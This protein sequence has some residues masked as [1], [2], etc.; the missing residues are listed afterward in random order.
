MRTLPH[1]AVGAAAAI[2]PDLALLALIG[3]RTW[4][5][6]THPVIRA[7]AFLHQSPAGLILAALIGW[8]SHLITDRYTPHRLSP[9]ETGHRGWRW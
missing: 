4:L 7:H 1:A 5:P 6:R 8:T 3:H 9:T 2:A